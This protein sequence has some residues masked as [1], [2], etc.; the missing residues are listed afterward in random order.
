MTST[1]RALA[2]LPLGL[3][4]PLAAC[5]DGE[6]DDR[7]LRGEVTL[8][9]RQ[10]ALVESGADEYADFVRKETA[11]LLRG[12]ARFVAAY[13]TGDDERARALYAPT[14]MH[15]EAI[16][17]VAE[18]FGDL[19]PRTDAREADLAEGEE[20]SGWHLIEKDLWPQDAGA[21][22]TPLTDA[23]RTEYAD[24]L[25]ADLTTLE[26]EVDDADYSGEQIANGAKELLDEV[27][28]GKVTGEEEIWS[29][30]DLYDFQANVDGAKKS[31]DVL[32]PVTEQTDPEL[33]DTLGTRFDDLQALLDQHRSGD[34]FVSYTELDDAEV[35]ELSDSVNALSEPLATLAAAVAP[36]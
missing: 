26:G 30:T 29:H 1:R 13:K 4:L 11:L 2:L 18:T 33:V 25:L 32:R 35:K 8:T 14:R 22:Y 21:G 36:R 23:E 5:S 28:S 27:A 3:L 15:W 20:W 10:T 31:F 12:T 34:G 17:P 7:A 19:D 16:E 24:R 9:A 6:A